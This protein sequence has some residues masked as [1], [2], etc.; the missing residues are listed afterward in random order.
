MRST[1]GYITFLGGNLVTWRSKKQT[2]VAHSSAEAELRALALGLCEGLWIKS[3]LKDLHQLNSDLTINV[4]CDNVSAIHMAENPVHHD[5]MKH[6]EIDR[7]FIREKME[8]QTLIIKHIYSSD[9]PGLFH[10]LLSK[11]GCTNIYVKLEG[12]C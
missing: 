12:G 11:L 9:S 1:S 5:K 8:Y 4:Y 10:K 2:V 7:H 3:V 6:V